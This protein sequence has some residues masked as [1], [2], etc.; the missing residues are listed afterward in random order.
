MKLKFE[1]GKVYCPDS[2]GDLPKE[3]NKYFSED[4]FQENTK[5]HEQGSVRCLKSF[6]IEF[7]I[8]ENQ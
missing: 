5:E 2:V 7:I 1:K 3:C 8:K 4:E 6:E